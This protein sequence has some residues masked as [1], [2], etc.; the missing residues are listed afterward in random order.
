MVGEGSG[1]QKR[2]PG[3][4][5]CGSI[6]QG[7]ATQPLGA[8][9]SHPLPPSRRPQSAAQPPIHTLGIQARPAARSRRPPRAR[10]RL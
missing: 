3:A 9:H 10:R 5:G 6:Q 8:S 4:G 1:G 7:P 2:P